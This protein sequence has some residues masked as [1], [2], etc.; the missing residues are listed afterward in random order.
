M[1]TE[2]NARKSAAK[3]VDQTFHTIE[4]ARS[5]ARQIG[6]LF[7]RLFGFGMKPAAPDTPRSMIV[8]PKQSRAIVGELISD[9]FGAMWCALWRRGR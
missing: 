3:T 2:L 7:D 9:I 8:N 1:P 6:G 4:T 5:G